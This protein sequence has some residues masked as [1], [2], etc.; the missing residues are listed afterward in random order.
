[1]SLPILRRAVRVS[2]QKRCIARK[3]NEVD[4]PIRTK[5][6]S[7][8]MPATIRIGLDGYRSPTPSVV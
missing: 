1:M 4:Q 6:L 7:D 5:P 8:S 3:V 2:R